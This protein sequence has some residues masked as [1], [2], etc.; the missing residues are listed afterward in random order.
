MRLFL[1]FFFSPSAAPPDAA[2]EVFFAPLE[3]PS[4]VVF[5]GA[6]EAVEA[7]AFP[8]VDAGLGAIGDEEVVVVVKEAGGRACAAGVGVRTRRWTSSGGRYAVFIRTRWPCLARRVDA[9]NLILLNA[10][11]SVT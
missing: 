9:L 10:I 7:G 6:L 8:A 1:R 3:A 4:E 11:S 5:A 2:L